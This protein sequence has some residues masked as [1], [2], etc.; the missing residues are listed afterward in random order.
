MGLKVVYAVPFPLEGAVAQRVYWLARALH[1]SGRVNEVQVIAPTISGDHRDEGWLR[2]IKAE[3]TEGQSRGV[4]HKVKR[5]VSLG[6]GTVAALSDMGRRPDLVIVYGGGS[7]YMERILKWGRASGV[8]ITADVVEWYDSSH[9]PLGR[10]GP[11]ALDN[12]VLMTRT[13]MHVD[14]VIAISRLLERHVHRGSS[15]PVIRIPPLVGGVVRQDVIESRRAGPIRLAYCGNPGKK[16]RLDLVVRAIAELDPLGG[17]YEFAIAGPTRQEIVAMT[18]DGNLPRSIHVLGRVSHAEAV[19]LVRR[20]DWVP[21]VRDDLRFANAGFPTKVVEALSVGTPVLANLTSDLDEVLVDGANAVVV[22]SPDI[23][24]VVQALER[25]RELTTN[26]PEF[27]AAA[28]LR[29]A[30]DLF[31]F[32]RH[33]PALDVWLSEVIGCSA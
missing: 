17:L 8:P 6:R 18:T 5:R 24:S 31:V 28:S 32:H 26:D 30:A 3:G 14:G 10:L 9:L 15:A 12:W 7:L 27:L 33:V 11:F 2:H 1:E 4:W 29:T 20:A 16:D 25:A 19:D 22:S 21:L 23:P 13:L